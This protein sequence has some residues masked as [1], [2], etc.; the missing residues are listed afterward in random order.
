MD[1]QTKQKVITMYCHLRR[2]LSPVETVTIVSE[3]INHSLSM[4]F[5][6]L[7]YRSKWNNASNKKH[8]K[9]WNHTY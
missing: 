6:E 9:Y 8:L 5:L 3:K 7:V 4:D 1:K 2:F